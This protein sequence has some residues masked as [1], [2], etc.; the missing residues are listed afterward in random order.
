MERITNYLQRFANLKPTER[1]V[2]DACISAVYA[3]CGI[4]LSH[5]DMDVRGTV[6][7][8]R[9]HSVIKHEISLHKK[10]VLHDVMA[11]LPASYTLQD[12]R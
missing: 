7:F 3:Q 2:K 5:T 8:L 11:R 6:V 9:S 12:I 10:A 4:T 1:I